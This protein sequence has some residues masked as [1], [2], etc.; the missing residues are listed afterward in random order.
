MNSFG[1]AQ[2]N[3]QVQADNIRPY[4]QIPSNIQG[5]DPSSSESIFRRTQDNLN[6]TSSRQQKMSIFAYGD[7]PLPEVDASFLVL[8]P[9]EIVI[10]LVTKYFELVATSNWFLHR[11]TVESWTRELQSSRGM[12]GDNSQRAV[13]LMVFAATHEYMNEFSGGEDE[14]RRCVT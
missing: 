9:P 6:Q 3:A 12:A 4:G 1:Q 2:L 5:Y 8:P 11:P 7:P 14:D 13:V 10:D